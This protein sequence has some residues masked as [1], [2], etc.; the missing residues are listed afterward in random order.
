MG[1]L[2]G[3]KCL[4]GTQTCLLDSAMGEVNGD[5]NDS[6]SNG[7]QTEHKE[8]T[9]VPDLVYAHGAGINGCL[10]VVHAR[11]VVQ[12]DDLLAEVALELGVVSTA[13]GHALGR[14]LPLHSRVDA[15]QRCGDGNRWRVR[16]G[17]PKGASF[18]VGPRRIDV[19]PH[20]RKQSESQRPRQL[21]WK[22]Q[23]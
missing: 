2:I 10:E 22:K 14:I 8:D 16:R 7:Q 15:N 1:S 4:L 9:M 21:A 20:V 18:N 23:G 17:R 6:T 3:N 5:A 13:V 12:A 19:C 11:V